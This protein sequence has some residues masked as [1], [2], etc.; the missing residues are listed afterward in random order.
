MNN[1][2]EL[3][4]QIRFQLYQ[5]SARNAHHEF[6]HL[7]RHLARARICSNILPATG[8]V[9]SGG[10]QGKD[11]ETYRTYL[12]KQFDDNA[13][14]GL[15]SEKPLAF[16]CTI[17][18]KNIYAKIKSD[19][20]KI[21]NGDPDIEGIH[22]FLTQDVPVAK[23][24]EI[25]EWC[26]TKH[27]ISLEIYD[28]Q[29]IAEFLSDYEMFWI[30]EKYLSIPNDLFPKKQNDTNWYTKLLLKWKS[31]VENDLNYSDFFEIKST[32][33]TATFDENYKLDLLFWISKLKIFSNNNNEPNLKRKAIYEIV[34][35]SLRGLK[36]LEC[37]FDEIDYYFES[38]NSMNKPYDFD[39]ALT[40]IT[41]C[42]GASC[43][44]V[45]SYDEKK[46]MNY[47][48]ILEKK[49]DD[50]I[51]REE[52]LTNIC[53]LYEIKGR[54]FI[55]P[56]FDGS[57]AF[58]FSEAIYFWNKT[59]DLAKDCPLYPLER[60]C[61]YIT[62]I[63]EIYSG[64]INE[65]YDELN[66]LLGKIDA[67]LAKR[68]GG[69][70]V[71]EKAKERAMKF[72]N[73]G[74]ITKALQ[75]MHISK[76]NWFA[77]EML[78]GSILSILAIG[79]IYNDLGL[80]YAAKYYFIAA[81]FITIET[82]KPEL[83]KYFIEA[84]SYL[85]NINYSNGQ[86]CNYLD[87]AEIGLVGYDI[88]GDKVVPEDGIDDLT[89][90]IHDTSF[91]LVITKQIHPAIYDVFIKLID[92]W[93][94]DGYFSKSIPLVEKNLSMGDTNDLW[95]K[96]RENYNSLPLNDLGCQ[97]FIRWSEL[98]ID[99]ELRFSNVYLAVPISEQFAAIAQVLLCDLSSVDLFLLQTKVSIEILVDKAFKY[100]IIPQ[101]SNKN[102]EW[103][104][105]FPCFEV[106]SE[107]NFKDIQSYCTD[108]I[109]KILFDLSL[110]P[111][112]EFLNIIEQCFNNDLI[113]KVFIARSYE[114]IYKYFL[115]V[116]QFNKIPRASFEPPNSP[117]KF[118]TKS[119][120]VLEWKSQLGLTYN[121]IKSKEFIQR[122]Y[123]NLSSCLR[124]TLPNLMK[125]NEFLSI[126]SQLKYKGW[127][128]W[129]ILMVI[130]NITLNYRVQ[131]FP[132]INNNPQKMKAFMEDA[133]SNPEPDDAI[134]IPVSYYSEI[135]MLE[136]HN[137]YMLT[138]LSA[139]GLECHQM[140]PD[141]DAI[142]KFLTYRFRY[143]GDDV[144]HEP[145]FTK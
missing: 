122:R 12:S 120:P 53:C 19:I 27:T 96:I 110:K 119:H 7:C 138:I 137:V 79:D 14:I 34:V 4:S 136:G 88:F 73:K 8:P 32:T 74:E 133:I 97:R 21:L 111:H 81:A 71:A 62:N 103:V 5:L 70:K 52:S 25:A 22:F 18:I 44:N 109:T 69:F 139:F 35:A 2:A 50:R 63:I 123:Q 143:W 39:E 11:F 61:D 31:K 26:K 23:R 42:V 57:K 100:E 20:N 102:R 28:G 49:L 51:K 54:T 83:K 95:T 64:F 68:F 46:L 106:I 114:S 75:Q 45:F 145:I 82:H 76:I 107:L 140:I 125:S 78:E 91:L 38:I 41:Y 84:I 92:N 117:Q 43:H 142:N 37:T 116:E 101:S 104:I 56:T 67:L 17:Q 98:G 55:L 33:R 58:N 80:T 29:A 126:V 113:S 24:H 94:L 3:I 127:K 93:G 89:K 105:K 9:S 112:D 10:D 135:S 15:T 16:A 124:F 30:A 36:T 118:I 65:Y 132:L 1:I 13:F 77:D 131:R 141:L 144:E 85:I 90:I 6:E 66:L 121:E 134:I 48:N 130:L 60:F 72:Y 47:K 108:A 128:D 99:W 115:A 59:A 40:L 86:W 129:H 87:F